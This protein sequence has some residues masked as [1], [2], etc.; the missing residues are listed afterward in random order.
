MHWLSRKRKYWNV[1]RMDEWMDALMDGKSTVCTA[2]KKGAAQ[3][4]KSSRVTQRWREK[5]L[6]NLPLETSQFFCL[7]G[8]HLLGRAA[9]CLCVCVCAHVSVYP[10]SLNM[11]VPQGMISTL[12]SS[13]GLLVD[14]FLCLFISLSHHV[15]LLTPPLYS[16][17]SPFIYLSSFCYPSFLKIE[18][19]SCLIFLCTSAIRSISSPITTVYLW[20]AVNTHWNLDRQ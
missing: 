12:L 20:Q 7:E 10:L 16:L 19:Q 8:F 18:L 14:Y 5:A 13:S 17:P 3:L 15:V 2:V 4:G 6:C 9:L 1:F 11:S